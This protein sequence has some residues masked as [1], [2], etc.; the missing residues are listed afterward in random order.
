MSVQFPRFSLER[1]IMTGCLFCDK[2][3]NL[4]EDPDEEAYHAIKVVADERQD[5]T[6][7][8]FY[9]LYNDSLSRQCFS[10]H[11]KCATS[12]VCFDDNK[13]RKKPK[14]VPNRE[15][16]IEPDEDVK[17]KIET[18]EDVKVKI[19]LDED[20]QVKIEGESVIKE[21][22]SYQSKSPEEIVRCLICDKQLDLVYTKPHS[23]TSRLLAAKIIYNAAHIKH[24]AVFKKIRRY[25]S[26]EDMIDKGIHYHKACY[27]NYVGQ[28]KHCQKKRIGN[29]TEKEMHEG[30]K[31]LLDEI[32]DKLPTTCFHL[33]FLAQRLA[34]LTEV[35]DAVVDEETV[36]SLL[37]A[38]YGDRLLFSYPAGLDSCVLFL[39]R[40][41]LSE[42]MKRLA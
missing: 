26:P 3:G 18:D 7:D 38:K 36:K 21:V 34:E 16:K 39:S 6:R 9:F 42:A 35:K 40:V 15:V 10:W 12:Y 37:I 20:V 14:I 24:D 8:K 11:V 41:P 33:S 2:P 31:K 19:E 17:V 32:D 30:L 23:F 25:R 28:P 4:V 22:P 13:R 1:P 29:I 5:A 27:V